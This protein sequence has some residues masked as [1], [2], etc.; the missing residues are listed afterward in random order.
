MPFSIKV[1]DGS[2]I[3]EEKNLQ[4]TAWETDL[5]EDAT[6]SKFIKIKSKDTY[7]RALLKFRNLRIRRLDVKP[8]LPGTLG[9]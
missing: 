3:E 7:P 5:S 8:E 9:R 1:W 4:P 2:G 6:A